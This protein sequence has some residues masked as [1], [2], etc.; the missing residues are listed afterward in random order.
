MNKDNTYE[1]LKNLGF[2]PKVIVDCGAA[3][4]DW[5]GMVR[6]L[7]PDSFILSIDANPWTNGSINGSTVTEI[8]VLSDEDNKEM[9]FYRKKDNIDQGTYC[10]GDSLFKEQTQHYTDVNTIEDKVFTTTL[11]TILNKHNKDNID[12]LKIDTQGSELIIM[13]G[14]G[15]ILHNV[16]F[17][18]L[19][20]SIIEYNIGGC[21][22]TDVVEF[23]KDD[24]EIFDIVDLQYHYSFLAHID[25]IFKNKKSKIVKPL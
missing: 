18:E 1:N 2:N 15:D 23:L 3:W 11:K 21:C 9:I 13:K 8:A 10:T 22:F 25:V 14:L 24:F 20:C 7:F 4:G 19:E 6:Q 12:L 5:T 17:I 16:E